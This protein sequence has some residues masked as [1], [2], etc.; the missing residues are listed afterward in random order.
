MKSV[1]F[2]ASSVEDLCN[3][4]H[5][6]LC[7]HDALDPAQSPLHQSPVMKHGKPCGLF[8]QVKGPRLVRAY[9]VWAGEE[10]RVLFYDSK[11]VRFA[12]TRLS[13]SPDPRKLAA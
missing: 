3:H 12:E 11:G 6:T 10:G 5:Q 9:A 4:V 7:S 1:T 8:F 13:E 2:S